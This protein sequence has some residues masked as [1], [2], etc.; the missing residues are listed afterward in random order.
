MHE[1]QSKAKWQN[2]QRNILYENNISTIAILTAVVPDSLPTAW[3]FGTMKKKIAMVLI[4][5]FM[6]SLKRIN[7][8]LSCLL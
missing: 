3:E 5:N 6:R 1:T 7:Y 4:N 8:S 2:L